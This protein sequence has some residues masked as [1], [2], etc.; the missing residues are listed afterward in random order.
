MFIY[1]HLSKGCVMCHWSETTVASFPHL[2]VFHLQSVLSFLKSTSLWCF[3]FFAMLKGI[4]RNP[5][6]QDHGKTALP[7]IYTSKQSDIKYIMLCT[8]CEDVLLV[9]FLSLPMDCMPRL[10]LQL[11]LGFFSVY[12]DY[13]NVKLF[14]CNQD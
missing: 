10:C 14:C 7:L 2:M 1:F 3:I 5:S 9:A 12:P 6:F 4:I 13:Q 8:F 11:T